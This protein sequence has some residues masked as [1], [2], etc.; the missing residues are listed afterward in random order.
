M[1]LNVKDFHFDNTGY[2]ITTVR[3]LPNGNVRI[4]HRFKTGD[5]MLADWDFGREKSPVRTGLNNKG[6]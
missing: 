2:T 3:Q 1:I 6:I 5:E 4:D